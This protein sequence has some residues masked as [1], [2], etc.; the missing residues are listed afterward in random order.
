MAGFSISYI[1]YKCCFVFGSILLQSHSFIIFL[2]RAYIVSDL[3][4]GDLST[5]VHK[6]F[7]FEVV[8]FNFILLPFVSLLCGLMFDFIASSCLESWGPYCL[9][10]LKWI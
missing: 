5:V 8:L 7:K 4:C 2:Q 10:F 6:S 1:F 9:G 3:H